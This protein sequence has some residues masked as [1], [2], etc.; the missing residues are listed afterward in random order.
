MKKY[1][2]IGILALIMVM[3]LAGAANTIISTKN[4][5]YLP[6]GGL[7]E[8][9]THIVL[10][11]FVD[12]VPVGSYSVKMPDWVWFGSYDIPTYYLPIQN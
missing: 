2:I 8:D 10:T 11:E 3:P 6:N 1:L 12:S 9:F 4:K 7:N 5:V